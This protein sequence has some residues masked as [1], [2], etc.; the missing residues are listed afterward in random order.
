MPCET[1]DNCPI[2]QY[3]NQ[4][5]SSH[6]FHFAGWKRSVMHSDSKGTSFSF[7]IS[8]PFGQALR[9]MM[10]PEPIDNKS[11]VIQSWA[12]WFYKYKLKCV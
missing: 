12:Q 1:A 5:S 2:A 7:S 9:H 8:L 4:S 10:F 3:D 6:R 11:S